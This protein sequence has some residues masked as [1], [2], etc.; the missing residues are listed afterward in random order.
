MPD[1]PD[2][3]TAGLPA[4]SPDAQTVFDALCFLQAPLNITRLAEF[5]GDHSTARGTHFHGPELRKLLGELQA[6]GLAATL[7]QGPWFAPRERG[8]PRF[9]ALL[10]DD[11]ARSAWW[12]SWRRLYRFDHSWHLELF[13]PEAMVGAIRV[14]VLAGGTP[15]A[16]ERLCQLSR[17]ASPEHPALLAAALLDPFDAGLWNALDVELRHRLLGT[18]LRHLGGDAEG[19][20]RPL[21]DW[22]LAEATPDAGVLHDGHRLR[23]AERLLLAGQRDACLRVL[24]GLDLP[25][26]Q[27]LRAAVDIAAGHQASG[28]RAF[29][30]AWKEAATLSGRRKQLFAEPTSWVYL[31]GLIAQPDPAAWTKARKFAAGE[32]G[33]RDADAYSFWGVWQEAID[34]RLGDA[35]RNPRRLLLNGISTGRM[36][37][38]Q[39]LS[40]WLLGAWL[41]HQPPQLAPFEA[42]SRALSQGFEH[43]GLPWLAMLTRRSAAL[44]LGQPPAPA[45]A[46]QPFP[47]GAP[48]DRWREALNAIVALGPVGGGVA[49]PGP[50]ALADRLI[51]TVL[52]DAHGRV[53]RIEPLEQKAGAR[54]LGKPKPASLAALA[55]RT[56]LPAHDAA[57]LR[58]VKKLPYGGRLTL[59][60]AQAVQALVRHPQVAWADA[61]LQL[62]EVTEGLPQLEVLTR[63]DHL[64]FKV[65]D[66]IRPDDVAPADAPDDDE[67][68]DD[69]WTRSRRSGEAGKPEV[70]L[71]RDGPEQ[72][73]LVRVTPAQLRVAELVSQGWQVPVAAR[74]EL[75]SALRVLGTH[76]QLAS[77]AEA[78]HEVPAS[79]VLRAELT[80]QGDGL[81]LRLVAAPFG[82]FGPRQAPG[83]GRERV[84]TV[85]QGITL[86]T[87]RDLAT[88]RAHLRA[89]V[90]AVDW[91][92]DGAHAWTLDDPEQALAVVEALAGLGETIVSEWPKGKPMRVRSVAAPQ[93]TLQVKSQGD[94]LQ[95]DGSLALDGGEVLRL[96]QLLELVAQGKRRYVALGDGDFL[97]LGDTLRQQLA[98]LRAIS[99]P[100]GEQ[101]RVA[102][103]AALAWSAQAGAPALDGDT[104]WQRRCEAWA[105]AQAQ[106][107][108]V[109]AG[110]AAELRDYQASGW[111]WLMRLAASGF[112]AVLADDMGLGKTLQTLA[113]LLARSAGGPA[114]VVAPTSVCG[115]WLAEAARFA[116][117]LQVEMYGDTALVAEPDDDS[118]NP[119]ADGDAPADSARQAA[120][121][122]QVQALGPGQV[123]VCSYGL[124]QLDGDI[125]TGRPWHTAVLDEAQAIKN[126]GTRRARAA[127]ALAADFKLAL[128]GTPVE[129]RLGELW[130]IMAFANPGLLG[131]AEQFNTRFAGPIERD[132]DAAASRRLR[133][134]VAPFLLRRTKAEVLADLPP[135]TEIVHEVVPG[136]KERALLEALRQQA[137]ASVAQALEGGAPGQAQMHI[138]AALTKLRRAACD[139]RLVAP[140]LGLVGAKVQEF[141]RL[142]QELVAGRHKALV[143][144]QFTDFL[145]LLRDRLDAAGLRYQYLDGSTPAAQRTQRVAAF[146]GG[147]GDFFLISLK[148]GGFGLNLTM[149]DYVII[150]DPWWNPAAEDQASGRAHRIGQQRPVTVY[151]LVTQG[152]IEDRIVQLHHHKR[153]LADGVLAGADGDTAGTLMDAAQMLALLRD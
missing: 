18:L 61:P 32:A 80:P 113:L 104:A 122:K 69:T 9:L 39:Q 115:N 43:A 48:T 49:A 140:E 64:Q 25:E 89:L 59:D 47:V 24:R 46:A 73:R 12:A 41:G 149:A 92:D 144:S 133:R 119:P 74:A 116:P 62:V 77:D 105:A 7:P 54:G 121:R 90:N 29:E 22:L 38:L 114:L 28:V 27:A 139:P 1:L 132:G 33:K 70:L 2:D 141:E 66:P 45:D 84:T 87:K 134:L 34:Q 110:L 26:A 91:L 146:Q 31:L 76:F 10:R 37:G 106:T 75:E 142:A 118:D 108:P 112:G 123:L 107:Y 8:W 51:W 117:G 109:P 63:G 95:L 120:R 98:D 56:D 44:L 6:A 94:W 42:E 16:F 19:V 137:E 86:S 82:D 130:A 102:A 150:A 13:A 36:H 129:N 99:T 78:G 85:H 55:K 67:D 151:R 11:R 126:A 124:L 72:A 68:D 125:L 100:Q 93:L 52:T 152:S 135:R 148:A 17:Q 143:F 57:V 128:T 96:K 3:A 111:L 79:A 101:Q 65:L 20:T 5:L 21:W 88:E 153:A 131:S 145:A 138:L 40:H 71:L 14:V 35:P 53:R 97:A 103:L 83:L 60:K 30:L 81:A 136:T 127:Q 23:L 58:A 50:D 15:Q 147:E 4:L